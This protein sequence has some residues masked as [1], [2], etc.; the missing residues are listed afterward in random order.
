MALHASSTI[1]F[2]ASPA[3]HR[4]GIP[5]LTLAFLLLAPESVRAEGNP[6]VA[7]AV[8][9]A[10][11]LAITFEAATR[12]EGGGS[13]LPANTLLVGRKLIDATAGCPA[14]WSVETF[15]GS[16]R[17]GFVLATDV[18][19]VS[20]QLDGL[21]EG[22]RQLRRSFGNT[23]LQPDSIQFHENEQLR[24]A[25]KEATEAIT[26]NASLPAA[27]RIPDPY[28]ARAEVYMQA[29]NY[30]AALDD[31]ASASAIVA[32]AGLDSR[33]QQQTAE[34]YTKAIKQLRSV[35]QPLRDAFTNIDLQASEHYNASQ[36]F[37]SSHDFEN[38]IAELSKSLSFTP[39][40]PLYWY[41]RAIAR[42]ESGD[43]HLAQSDAL[44]GALFERRLSPR[45]KHD[46]SRGL[47]R[48][49]G[50]TRLW[51]EAYRRG[52]ADMEL[53]ELEL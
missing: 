17:R 47:T 26:A 24:E 45:A 46:I 9:K 12:G 38:A 43:L 27:Q 6:R 36:R 5:L 31:C 40:R 2:P 19:R 37:I 22:E 49:Q 42:H 34:I 14:V 13:P 3:L 35:P 52:K 23:A 39:S 41:M 53:L 33:K 8:T 4:Y 29:E 16:G 32:T 25:W 51:L 21:Q 7:L 1:C 15:D 11:T 44:L 20:R 10:S 18:I 28:F 30:V 50:P 48:V